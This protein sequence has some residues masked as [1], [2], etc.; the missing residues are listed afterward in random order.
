MYSPS[1]FDRISSSL[2]PVLRKVSDISTTLFGTKVNLLRISKDTDS[3]TGKPMNIFGDYDQKWG[4][5]ILSN[6]V[7]KYPFSRVEIFSQ[8][9]QTDYS[10]KTTGL[11]MMELLPIK[12]QLQFY[13]DFDTDPIVIKV[14][15]IL[16]DVLFDENYN[17]IPITMEVKRTFGSFFGKDIV[18]KEA[19]MTLTRGGLD[20]QIQNEIDKYVAQTSQERQAQVANGGNPDL[21]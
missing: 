21:C 3:F 16:V 14:G 13:G 15:D 6:V 9:N 8:L 19:E 18:S 20:V 1:L 2:S 12:I 10:S 7:V 17:A 11:D 4:S 5:S